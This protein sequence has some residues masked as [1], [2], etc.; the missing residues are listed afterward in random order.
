MADG[1]ASTPRLCFL[2]AF[3]RLARPVTPDP[4]IARPASTDREVRATGVVALLGFAAL[5]WALARRGH[6]VPAWSLAG[7]GLAW[8]LLAWASPRATRPLHR[9]WMRL[10]ELIG[11]VT[12][13]LL[14]VAV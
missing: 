11:H 2:P 14:L 10:G 1:P 12:T 8:A 9:A 6:H 13:P 3:P 4:T 7:A 5:G